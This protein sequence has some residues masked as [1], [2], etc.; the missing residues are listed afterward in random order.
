MRTQAYHVVK[1][2]Q[3]TNIELGFIPSGNKSYFGIYIVQ[4]NST[5]LSH[6]AIPSTWEEIFQA[7]FQF[8]NWEKLRMIMI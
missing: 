8:A 5:M 6:Y 4:Y 7:I 1:V 3:S 2:K